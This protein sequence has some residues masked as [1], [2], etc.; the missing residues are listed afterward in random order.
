MSI[1]YTSTAIH[2]PT[3][4]TS[5]YGAIMLDLGVFVDYFFAHFIIFMYIRVIKD[6]GECAELQKRSWE[7][8]K[9]FP[10][11][12][13]QHARIRLRPRGVSWGQ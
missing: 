10:N 6:R 11:L 2:L 5:P 7:Q 1:L 13:P 12:Q 8:H 9:S 3:M 4:R